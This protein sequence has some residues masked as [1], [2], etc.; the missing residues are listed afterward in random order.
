MLSTFPEHYGM[1]GV[2]NHSVIHYLHWL[3]YFLYD[4]YRGYVVKNSEDIW[5]IK[6]DPHLFLHVVSIAY[7]RTFIIN[8]SCYLFSKSILQIMNFFQFNTKSCKRINKIIFNHFQSRI[9]PFIS[10]TTLLKEY[11]SLALFKECG[12]FHMNG[13]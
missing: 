7:K 3:L 9:Y 10:F 8:L 1:S 13:G 11:E 4:N 2:F 12:C 5:L 6:F